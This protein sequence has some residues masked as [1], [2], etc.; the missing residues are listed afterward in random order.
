MA[1]AQNRTEKRPRKLSTKKQ[2]VI[3]RQRADSLAALV[4]E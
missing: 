2:L 4:E 1:T 3:E